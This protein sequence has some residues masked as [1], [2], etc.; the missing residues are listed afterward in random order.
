MLIYAFMQL[1]LKV[2]L[3]REMLVLSAKWPYGNH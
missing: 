1:K 3:T 2:N